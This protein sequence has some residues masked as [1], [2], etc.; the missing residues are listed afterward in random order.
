M[1]D[2]PILTAA[3]ISAAVGAILTLLVAFGVAL[4]TG[5]IAAIMGF[6]TILGPFIVGYIT[7]KFT[8]TEKS[9]KIANNM[10]ANTPIAQIDTE[11][12]A[13]KASTQ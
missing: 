13:V 8:Y 1:N 12:A 3:G 10:E 2:E 4:S 6:V 5:Q 11:I 7:R 9:V